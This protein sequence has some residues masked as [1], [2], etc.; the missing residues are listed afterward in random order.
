MF[1]SP[2]VALRGTFVTTCKHENNIHQKCICK[3]V[4]HDTFDRARNGG[5]FDGGDGML[6]QHSIGLRSRAMAGRSKP[7]VGASV[8]STFVATL[9][10]KSTGSASTERGRGAELACTMARVS[11]ARSHA[12]RLL[13]RRWQ[14]RQSTCD[15]HLV[16]ARRALALLFD[17]Q[18]DDQIGALACRKR[19]TFVARTLRARRRVGA[20]LYQFGRRIVAQPFAQL[21]GTARVA[22]GVVEGQPHRAR[23]LAIRARRPRA[24]RR[25]ASGTQQSETA[26]ELSRVPHPGHGLLS[27]DCDSDFP[28]VF[29]SE[30]HERLGEIG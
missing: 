24:S 2:G 23:D 22:H 8:C 5:R 26:L 4:S 13:K 7:R 16:L 18:G 11:S 15:T 9:R 10:S 12:P 3:S 14:P 25:L 1:R 20:H 27:T 29:T 6:Q 17:E 19:S 21:C 30:R 28:S